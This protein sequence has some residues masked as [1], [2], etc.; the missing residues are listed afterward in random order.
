M[1]NIYRNLGLLSFL[2][3]TGSFG[4]DLVS[5]LRD[6]PAPVEQQAEAKAGRPGGVA[7]PECDLTAYQSARRR[8]RGEG[9]GGRPSL[10]WVGADQHY[11]Y[12]YHFETDALSCQARASEGPL[13]S[14]SLR[15]EQETPPQTRFAILTCLA[16]I[17][18]SGS[19]LVVIR[20]MRE[21]ALTPPD[22]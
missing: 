19:G 12:H 3:A 1:P 9:R 7:G 18:L 10:V 15:G 21:K 17:G 5:F 16:V 8:L 2:L 11:D 22:S 20:R 6:A 13:V 4:I 14:P